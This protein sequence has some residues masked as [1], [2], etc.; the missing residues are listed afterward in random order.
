MNLKIKTSNIY[1]KNLEAKTRFIFNE[2]G[3]RSTKTYSL[4]QVC[5]TLA[6]ESKTPLII[7]IV[8]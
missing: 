5:Y 6:A 1:F 4:N 8:S 2:G 3:T 7:S